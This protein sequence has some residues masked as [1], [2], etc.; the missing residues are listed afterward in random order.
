MLYVRSRS[1]NV[2]CHRDNNVPTNIF[3]IPANEQGLLP[4]EDSEISPS[5]RTLKL[6]VFDTNRNKV[7]RFGKEISPVITSGVPGITGFSGGRPKPQE[8]IAYWPALINKK[9]INT[10]VSII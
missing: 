9:F 8:V 7:S 5:I 4:I 2:S 10:K 6:S 1:K 3:N